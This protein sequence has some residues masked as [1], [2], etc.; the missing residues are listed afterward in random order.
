[1][2][3]TG[4]RT[5]GRYHL[6]EDYSLWIGRIAVIWS[7]T[8][9]ALNF[10]I[11]AVA[12]I[13]PTLGACLTSQIYAMSGRWSALLALLKIRRAPQRLIDLVNEMAE[14]SR[15]PLEIRNRTVHDAWVWRPDG[16]VGRFEITAP[17]KLRFDIIEIPLDE[18]KANFE[19]LLK[20]N[21][22]VVE[23]RKT[24]YAA[25][26]SLPEMSPEELRPISD[27]PS[28]L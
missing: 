7:S 8:E 6:H 26:P 17:K 22:R 25:L 9:N 5:P 13:A 16:A 24:I 3:D 1:M 23:M 27:D 19:T 14:A 4:H 10:C 21:D 20:F 12:G 11:W 15:G 28:R 18:L 2:S